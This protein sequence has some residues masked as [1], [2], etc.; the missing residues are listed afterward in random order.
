M[1]TLRRVSLVVIMG[2]VFSLFLTGIYV[3]GALAQQEIKISNLGPFT[4]FSALGGRNSSRGAH[5]AVDEINAA[6]GIKALK[7]AKLK[8]IDADTQGITDVG[9]LEAKRCIEQE[10]VICFVNG[11][12]S[13]VVLAASAVAEKAGVPFINSTGTAPK[14]HQREFKY[15]AHINPDSVQFTACLI[16]FI[17]Q[18]RKDMGKN[19]LR[20][21]IMSEDSEYGKSF[22]KAQQELLPE[23]GVEIIETLSFHSPATDLTPQLLKVKSLKPD[24]LFDNGLY[25]DAVLVAKGLVAMDIHLLRFAGGGMDDPAY[26]KT[27]GKAA[28]GLLFSH[29]FCHDVRPDAEKYNSVYKAKYGETSSSNAGTMYHTMHLVKYILEKGGS[30][31]PDIIMKT[32]RAGP[33]TPADFKKANLP[34]IVPYEAVTLNNEGYNTSAR[35]VLIQIQN[36]DYNTVYPPEY[37]KG[38]RYK[39]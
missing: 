36:E 11:F 28:N 26:I 24:L 14:I 25:S 30:T 23:A 38:N 7:G 13:A 37:S 15:L 2:C 3:N 21:V 35:T 10:K 34:W 16:N 19:K 22:V 32:L 39:P 9:V 12:N 31:N 33:I 29:Y 20:A 1:K 4:G 27:L 17:K 5:L 18:V 6:G 8:L